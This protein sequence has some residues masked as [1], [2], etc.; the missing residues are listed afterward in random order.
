MKQSDLV[1]LCS[2]AVLTTGLLSFSDAAKASP[3]DFSAL[4]FSAA[5]VPTSGTPSP[6]QL[7]QTM[8]S[9]ASSSKALS[10]ASSDP[11]RA[12]Q[13]PQ[14]EAPLGKGG[15]LATLPPPP[16][17]AIAPPA[18]SDTAPGLSASNSSTARSASTDAERA[19]SPTSD[20]AP[21]PVTAIPGE[22]TSPTATHTANGMLSFGLGGLADDSPVAATPAVAA[23]PPVVPPSSSPAPPSKATSQP[24]SH[25]APAPVEG[26]PF[27]VLPENVQAMFQGDS[28]SLVA[29]AVGNAEG[30]RTPSGGKTRAYSGH[31]D[32]GNGVWNLGSFSYQHGADT[33]EEADAKQLKRL[34]SQTQELMEGASE[35]GLSLTVEAVLNG[36]DLANQSPAAALSRG[37]YIDRLAQAEEMGLQGTE[38]ILWARTRSYLDPDSGRWN[39]PGLGNTV[40]SIT[41]DQQRRMDAIASA[42]EQ[43]PSVSQVAALPQ[44]SAPSPPQ[45]ESLLDQLFSINIDFSL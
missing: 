7:A 9:V 43:K 19:V 32:P 12:L 5:V 18:P 33:P 25:P 27:P 29:I 15:K 14:T 16:T 3:T 17:A 8:E 24:T 36:I 10:A 38:A 26:T 45:E 2:A 13:V 22:T 6:E 40:G 21:D 37:G 35:K 34:Q 1:L 20:P 23:P 39:A 42:L 30:T 4:D 11:N 41:H 44:P 28:D 31:S